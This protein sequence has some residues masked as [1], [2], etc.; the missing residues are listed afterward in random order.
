MNNIDHFFI[1]LCDGHGSYGHLISKY[2]CDILPKKMTKL[3]D[4]IISEVI[5]STNKSLIEESKID[6]SLSGTTCTTLLI[7]P[8]KIVSSNVGDTRA[9]IAQ[10]E[11]GQ[12]NA[13]D[14]TRDH[15]PKELDEMKRI[16]N[17]DGRIKQYTDPKTG[18]A[19]GPQK[20]WKYQVYQS[21]EVL[22]IIWLT[23]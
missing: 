4:D 5:L 10:Y 8:E 13:K 11:N 22:G 7:Y 23:L 12:Y 20:I 14:L 1:G 16:I 17:S 19:I 9:V 3:S 2:I 15:K 6:C 21:R 18:K